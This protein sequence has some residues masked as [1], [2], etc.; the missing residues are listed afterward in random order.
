MLVENR[1][2]NGRVK[3]ETIAV[4][5]SIEATWLPEFWEGIDREVAANLKAEKWELYSLRERISF[6]K[7]ANRRLKQLTNRLGPDV[8]RIRMAAHARV[9][10]PM[11]AG[12]KRLVLMETKEDL[13]F[14]RRH[15][16]WRH[17]QNASHKKIIERARVNPRRRAERRNSVRKNHSGFLTARQVRLSID[18]KEGESYPAR[19]EEPPNSKCPWPS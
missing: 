6:W 14:W 5:G 8:K 16:G 13:D 19:S 11:E 3:Q 18:A 2:V 1:R 7:I 17:K 4:L 12:V 10:W 15:M 9:P